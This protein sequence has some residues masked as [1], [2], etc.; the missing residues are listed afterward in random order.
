M[1]DLKT[2]ASCKRTDK[3]QS[4]QYLACTMRHWKIFAYNLA[5]VYNM[6]TGHNAINFYASI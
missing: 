2:L 1:L 5:S 6:H 3:T 4:A